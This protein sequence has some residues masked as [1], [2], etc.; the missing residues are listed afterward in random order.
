MYVRESE[1]LMDE[2]KRVALKVLES[3]SN[4]KTTDWNIIKTKV[5]D[6]LYRL[7]HNRTRRNPVILPVIM[8]V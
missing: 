7:F 1:H 8:E 6:E 2:A 5:R 3:C 4:Q